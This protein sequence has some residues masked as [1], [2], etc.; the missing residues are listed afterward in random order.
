MRAVGVNTQVWVMPFT[1]GDL[2]LI[3]KAADL[4]FDAIELSYTATDPT[5][6][7]AACKRALAETGLTPV[8]CGFMA[9][10]RDISS[11]DEAVQR[12]GVEYLR[13]A[14]HTVVEL[15]GRVVCGPLYA[16]LFRARHLPARERRDEWQRSVDGMVAAAQAAEEAGAQIA[17]E[18]LNRFETDLINTT[19]AALAYLDEVSSEAVGLLLDTFHMN[20]EERDLPAAIRRAGDRLIHFH[21][22]ENDRGAPGTGHVDWSSV[23][24]ALTDIGYDGL[25]VIE[26]FNREVT[27]LA[28]GARIWRDLAS[29]PDDLASTGLRFLRSALMS[30]NEEPVADD[31]AVG[32]RQTK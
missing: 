25:L 17:V 21:T 26:A 20:I 31:L 10:D 32:P 3:E 6:D 29:S 12:R 24:A 9:G 13:R 14:C 27:D 18:P 30:P 22:C 16:E 4:G 7:V 11:A 28:N 15:G 1:D 23:Q 5:F 2:G 19:E 8:L